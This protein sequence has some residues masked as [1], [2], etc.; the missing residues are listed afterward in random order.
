MLIPVILAGGS[1]TR[2]WPLSRRHDPKPFLRLPDGG[3]LVAD[4]LARAARV[5]EGAGLVVCGRDHARRLAELLPAELSWSF[6]IEPVGRNTAPAILAAA[7]EIRERFGAEAELLALPADHRIVPHERFAADVARAR[8]I[9]AEGA[10]V[11]FGI[12]PDRPAT[13]FG[14]IEPGAPWHEGFRIESFV[15]KPERA[16][17]EALL[18]GGRHLWNAGMFLAR[19]GGLLAAAAQ[20]APELLAA[21]TAAWREGGRRGEE[22][23]L[24]AEGWSRLP[25]IAFDHAVM[26]RA[27]ERAVVP[28]SFAWSD[29]GDFAALA[30]MVP[31]DGDGN[32]LSGRALAIGARDCAVFAAERPVVLLGTEAI[33]VA[34]AG[35][36]VLVLGRGAEQRVREA[37][38]RLAAAGCE[39]A[40]TPRTVHRP[41]GSYT[42]L[43]DAPD[44][45]VKRLS[46]RPGG[47]L[48]L[49]RHRR[50]S[51]HWTVVR[52]T[53]KVRV[54][55]RELVLGRNESVDIP[56][57]TLHRLENPG[58]GCA[59]DDRGADRGLLRRGRH[60]APR[61]RLR[62]GLS[63]AQPAR[64]SSSRRASQASPLA[65]SSTGLISQLVR[66]SASPI[67]QSR[68]ASENRASP[69]ATCSITARLGAVAGELPSSPS[70]PVLRACSSCSRT[71][72]MRRRASRW[73][74]SPA[75]S[76]AS[77]ASARYSAVTRSCQNSRSASSPARSLP[78]S[79]SWARSSPS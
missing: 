25:E 43:E 27:A 1:G 76:G 40:E 38:A 63:P 21:C 7:L 37:V 24:P 41:W 14:W 15:E 62:P 57:G 18:A 56:A 66:V 78:A 3:P 74:S 2:L 70:E 75:S 50:R 64:R 31:A 51:E 67:T 79:S 6:L 45:K 35:D 59:R 71:W 17:A 30:A 58:H 32:R 28:A 12:R 47:I 54:G 48:S 13:G 4:A 39:Q 44:C 5:G 52:G 77:S 29:I 22:L 46:V 8:R 68:W 42:V 49:Q 16:R 36:A 65:R 19:A 73:G 9:A 20:V 34:D 10:V 61:G 55:E 11:V 33:T 72:A 23:R 53:A 26:E 60:R 69:A